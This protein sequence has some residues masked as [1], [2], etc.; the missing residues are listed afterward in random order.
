MEHLLPLPGRAASD[1]LAERISA[2]FRD[3]GFGFWAVEVAGVAPFIGFAGLAHVRFE[4]HFTPA[5]EIGWRI[6]PEYWGQG[7]AT[8]AARLA[9]ED[10]FGRLGLKE[11]VAF[12]V[13]ANRRSWRVME[14][15]GM[16]R[17]ERDDFDHPR[18]PDGHVL[19]RHVL[20]RLRRE[21]WSAR[22]DRMP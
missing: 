21:V 10:G 8:E 17:V 4:A 18:V 6:A 16:G 19:K 11:I 5:V 22:L 12:T 15:L 3:H 9:L 13:P 1:A 7:Y 2:H 20:Y 14:R